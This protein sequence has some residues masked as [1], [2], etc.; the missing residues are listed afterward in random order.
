MEKAM[1]KVEFFN[2]LISIKS[3]D[4]SNEK[5]ID[6]DMVRLYIDICRVIAECEP[7]E[8]GLVKQ[9][10][11]TVAEILKGLG[12]SEIDKLVNIDTD[13]LTEDIIVSEL[14]NN[15]NDL[16][17][18]LFVIHTLLK[19]NELG[20]SYCMN[21]AFGRGNWTETWLNAYDA[22]HEP[23]KNDDEIQTM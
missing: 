9:D 11:I 21:R 15:P 4:L 22:K 13:C 16:G 18:P 5:S 23:T 3:L 19:A 7:N 20:F 2:K 6:E 1:K 10:N 14:V 12:C 8:I 17:Y